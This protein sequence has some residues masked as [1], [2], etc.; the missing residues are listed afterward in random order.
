MHDI[1]EGLPAAASVEQS[2]IFAQLQILRRLDRQRN[3]R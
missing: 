3:G 1:H 2:I